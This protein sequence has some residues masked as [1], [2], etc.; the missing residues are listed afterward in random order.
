MWADVGFATNQ[1]AKKTCDFPTATIGPAFGVDAQMLR[2][3]RW[4]R[5][6]TTSLLIR[7]ILS[8]GLILAAIPG[9]ILRAESPNDQIH[10]AAELN[11]KG[12]FRET[13][14]VLAPLLRS[15][16][17]NNE[18]LFG[19]AWN[20]NGSALQSM[21]DEDGARRSYE[22]AIEILRKAPAEKRTLA[23]VFDNLGS[24]KAEMG[25]LGEAES[26][27]IKSRALYEAVG[28]HGGVARS[29][30]NLAL[31][32]LD[33]GKRKQ[34]RRFLNE[35]FSAEAKV[36]T[37]DSGDLSVLYADQALERKAFRDNKGALASIDKAIHLWIEHYG[38]GYYLLSSG[39]SLRGQLE[40]ELNDRNGAQIDF[41]NSF[42]ILKLHGE[43]G[44]RA[45]FLVEAAYAKTLRRFG[46]REDAEKMEK[47]AQY[48]L[49]SIRN[50]CPG[51]TLSANSIR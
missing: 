37:P 24:L 50:P 51:C 11:D 32:A 15:Q 33:Q 8:L 26:L 4:N 2:Y 1:S 22:R 7:S 21:G 40:A 28:D 13:L 20:I 39:Y 45:Y 19:L 31:I 35:A 46:M 16:G 5:L 9:P 10:R 27:G 41:E 23:S 44:S 25:Q 17:L 3:L 14:E 38:P 29:S 49:K 42:E 36:A 34:M 43:V 12:N 30:I 18:P 6:C 47:A 48:G